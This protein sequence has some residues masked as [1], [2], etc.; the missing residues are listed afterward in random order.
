MSFLFLFSGESN[1]YFVP[2]VDSRSY[3]PFMPKLP[4]ETVIQGR[5][6]NLP[7]LVG[8]NAQDGVSIVAPVWNRLEV[9]KHPES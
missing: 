9:I 7:Y 3:R 8:Q 2:T 6:K 1:L 4:A 5:V